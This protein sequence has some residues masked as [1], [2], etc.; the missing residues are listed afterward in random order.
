MKKN[1]NIFLVSTKKIFRNINKNKSN[2]I[3]SF[4]DNLPLIKICYKQFLEH[5]W[6]KELKHKYNVV[7]NK[8]ELSIIRK[9]FKTNEDK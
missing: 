6:E 9:I 1:Y 2:N 3:I 8:K 7:I 4:K 5:I